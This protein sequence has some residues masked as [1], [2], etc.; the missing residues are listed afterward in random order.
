MS[1]FSKDYTHRYSKS[2]ASVPG[3]WC[4]RPG[5]L[6]TGRAAADPS[7]RGCFEACLRNSQCT[8]NSDLT[9]VF[10]ADLWTSLPSFISVLEVCALQTLHYYHH[11]HHYYSARKRTC[12]DSHSVCVC[13]CE[14][15]W[16]CVCMC[17]CVCVCLSVSVTE[18]VCTCVCVCV[19]VCVDGINWKCPLL[20]QVHIS[21]HSVPCQCT[22]THTYSCTYTHTHTLIPF[23]DHKPTGLKVDVTHYD[24]GQYPLSAQSVHGAV[25]KHQRR[26]V[27]LL[28]HDVQL[29]APIQAGPQRVAGRADV[30]AG[31]RTLHVAQHKL[32][33]VR[34]M[35]KS[36]PEGDHWLLVRQ[37]IH[38]QDEGFVLL[39]EPAHSGGGVTVKLTPDRHVLPFL[40]SGFLCFLSVHMQWLQIR[41]ICNRKKKKKKKR[42]EIS[43][44][45]VF[46]EMMMSV[47]TCMLFHS[48]CTKS[49]DEKRRERL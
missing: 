20:W 39:A 44:W 40:H 22:C 14:C 31:V 13:V 28:T 27:Q 9:R 4:G 16:M 41:A 1:L 48:L 10:K 19:C 23:E 2:L 42:G 30:E 12:G 25:L 29:K 43:Y 47:D 24:N 34:R 21:V 32:W 37:V 17:V 11:H 3:R 45:C 35:R 36:S 49:V 18:C 7:P 33:R 46:E 5:L 26:D 6:G 15:K 8:V 38:G